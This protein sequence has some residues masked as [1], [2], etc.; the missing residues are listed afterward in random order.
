LPDLALL[1]LDLVVDGARQLVRA[2]RLPVIVD[3]DTG[4]GGV[5]NVARTVSEL[6]AAGVAAVQIEDQR[7]PKRCGHLDGKELVPADEMAQKIAAACAVRRKMAIIARTDARAVEGVDAALARARLYRDAGADI[8]F[9]EALQTEEELARV[10]A[11]LKGTPLLANM[12]EFGKSPLLSAGRLGALGYHIVIFPAS[13]LRVAS[14]AIEEFY[15]DLWAEGTQTSWVDRMLTRHELYDLIDYEGYE[16]F[17]GQLEAKI[18]GV[19]A[20]R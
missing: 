11:D 1:T 14:R 7:I 10:G 6:E 12:T 5:L 4:F 13:A 8:I 17:D 19:A 3:A 20:K 2:A 16:A 18:A 9:P 15:A